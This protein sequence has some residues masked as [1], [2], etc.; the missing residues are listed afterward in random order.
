M[1]KDNFRYEKKI[2]VP[3]KKQHLIKNLV[4]LS[5]MRFKKQYKDRIV[6][7]LYFDTDELKFYKTNIEGLNIRK[8]FRIRW[9]GDLN[10]RTNIYFEIKEKR[11][12]LGSKKIFPIKNNNFSNKRLEICDLIKAANQLRIENQSLLYLYKLRPKLKVSYLR[13]YYISATNNCRLTVDQKISYSK[14]NDKNYS[15]RKTHALIDEI[16]IELKYSSKLNLSILNNFLNMPFRLS[17]NSKYV[18]GLKTF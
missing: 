8:K 1:G 6:N 9:Y 15:I 2:I 10:H 14:V 18:N 13:E 5:P 7:S 4:F 16:V 11:G 3:F 12:H 17:R